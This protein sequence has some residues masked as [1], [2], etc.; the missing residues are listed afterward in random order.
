MLFFTFYILCIIVKPG[1]IKGTDSSGN[2]IAKFYFSHSDIIKNHQMNNFTLNTKNNNFIAVW[3]GIKRK[4]GSAKGGKSPLLLKTLRDII[5][6]IDK[7][8]KTNM[9]IRNK[10]LIIFS[11]ASAMRRAEI[12]ALNWSDVEY[13]EEG[14]L[15][16]ICKSKTDK[17]SKGQKIAIIYGK[18]EVTCPVRNL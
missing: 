4:L 18:Y 6:D 2:I 14:I 1:I 10:A 3:S 16:T 7:G 12:V 15:V 11:W 9:A 5:D 13:V 17:Y 8:Q